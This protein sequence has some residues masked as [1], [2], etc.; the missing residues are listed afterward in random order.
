MSVD[1]K[2]G[3][4]A[5]ERLAPNLPL[6][7]NHHS[8]GVE[9]QEFDYSR[10]GTLCLIANLEVATG[11][12]CSPT[13]GPTRTEVDFV[14]H[15]DRT[16]EQDPQAKWVFVCDQLNTHL[17]EGLVRLL[18]SRC[19]ITDELGEKGKSGILESKATRKVFL[20]DPT[21]RIRFIYTPIH[22]SWLN[23]VEIWF[24][25]LV[26]R[27]LKRGNFPSLEALEKRLLEFIAYFNRT[28]AKPFKWTYTGRPLA[29]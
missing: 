22:T 23:Q 27:V 9:R 5:L 15:I 8:G 21:H 29:A 6:N 16:I 14:K 1:E 17:S 4:Q 24:S 13:V 25:I 10:H 28:I 18:A 20:E 12:L 19:Q 7:L 26:R 2:T 3:I 11:V